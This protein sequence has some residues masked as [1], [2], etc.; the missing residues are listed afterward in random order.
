MVSVNIDGKIISVSKGTKL[1]DLLSVP[2]PCG[3][4]GRCG[5]CKVFAQGG[6]SPVSVP[7]RNQLTSEELMN[8]IRLACM[9]T[10]EG[11]CSIQ[12]MNNSA[13]SKILTDSESEIKV[14]EPIFKKYGLAVD[15]GTTT[16]AA[17]LYGTDGKSLCETTCMNPQAKWGA[18]VISRIEAAMK[19]EKEALAKAIRNELSMIAE[20]SAAKIGISVAEIDGLVITGNTAM[21]HLLTET[22]VSPLSKAPFEA[23]RLFG[24]TLT[25]KELEIQALSKDAEIYLPPCISAF[26][27]ADTVC[28]ILSSDME[29]SDGI[30]LLA[31]IGT[32]G[33]MAL[34]H[35]NSLTACSTAAG[36]A[37][38]GAGISMG[39][40]GQTGAIDHT[41]VVDG[42]IIPHVIGDTTPI[43]ICGSG[44]IDAI[45]CLLETEKLD[46]SGYLEDDPVEITTPVELTQEDIRQ[47]QL[48]KSAIFAGIKT[49]LRTKNISSSDISTLFIAGGFGSYLNVENSGK[50]G[51]LPYELTSKTKVIG[52]AAL[53]GASILLLNK[54]FAEKAEKTAKSAEVITLSAN[55]I[56][57]EEYMEGMLFPCD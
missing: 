50:I 40:G 34:F 39:M 45:K 31:D 47:V 49:M 44:L 53:S 52:N 17:K 56:F 2:M 42:K 7:E 3:G 13:E 9:V 1:K 23:R 55:P 16:I 25:A 38:E 12:T 8:G 51:L 11:D 27:G 29:N 54:S 48:A 20:T 35:N 15:I 24:E 43:G 33:E 30:S 18:D 19:G 36:P 5:K 28:A 41:E 37:F 21:L 14:S 46:D 6:L 57:T 4:R 10:V 32:N 22:D 26:I